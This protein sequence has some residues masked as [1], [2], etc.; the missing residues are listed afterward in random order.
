MSG[1]AN[2]DEFLYDVR[3]RCGDSGDTVSRVFT[4][5]C[6]QIRES[7]LA[8]KSVDLDGVGVLVV[9]RREVTETTRDMTEDRCGRVRIPKHFGYVRF[10]TRSALK[11]ELSR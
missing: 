5:V 1:I 4:A 8:G 10:M 2:R 3:K 11:R 7:L 9:K 6:E